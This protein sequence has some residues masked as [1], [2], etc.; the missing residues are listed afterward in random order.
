MM[1]PPLADCTEVRVEVCLSSTS[2]I[3]HAKYTCS[4][5]NISPPIGVLFQSVVQTTIRD[6]TLRIPDQIRTRH[7][8]L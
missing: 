1:M 5:P 4:S 8:R 3:D 7:R 2:P 6:G